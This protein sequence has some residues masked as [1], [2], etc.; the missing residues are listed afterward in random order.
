MK[1]YLAGSPNLAA[2]HLQSV[3]FLQ[4]GARIDTVERLERAG[5]DEI[6]CL[7]DFGV[8]ADLVLEGLERLN[9][10]KVRANPR[11]LVLAPA[12][13][14]AGTPPVALRS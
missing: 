7:I 4:Q 9:V 14:L 13:A 11:P 6:A 8:G 12:R 3:P 2:G 1:R 10:V 5:V